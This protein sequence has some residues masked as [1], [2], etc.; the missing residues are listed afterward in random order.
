[1]QSNSC[2]LYNLNTGVEDNKRYFL[3]FRQRIELSSA[4]LRFHEK[5]GDET[6]SLRFLDFGNTVDYLNSLGITDRLGNR[7]N[8]GKLSVKGLL[9]VAVSNDNLPGRVYFSEFSDDEDF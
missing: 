9:E 8:F 2:N 6:V 7:I 3:T 5:A 4:Y 1:M